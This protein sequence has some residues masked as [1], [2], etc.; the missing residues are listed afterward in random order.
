M[1]VDPIERTR[2]QTRKRKQDDLDSTLQISLRDRR[3]LKKPKRYGEACSV[4]VNE[5]TS[6]SD[7]MLCRD[8][9]QWRLAI[10]EELDSLRNND[11][12]EIIDR[13]PKAE[14]IDTK[15]VFKVKLDSSGNI[16][17]YKARLCAR[18]FKQRQGVNYEETYAPVVRYE[19]LRV[20]FAVA[21]RLDLEMTQFDVKTAFLYG[22][23]EEEI[24]IEIPVGLDI[25]ERSR[26]ACRLKKALYGLKQASRCWN[27]RFSGFLSKHGFVRC[28]SEWSVFTCK[29]GDGVMF[30]ALFVD[31]GM[32]FGSSKVK[33]Q[34]IIDE[35]KKRV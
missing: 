15:W 1:E 5:P 4:F 32:I 3:Y 27:K 20:L 6:H 11:T 10:Q 23:L 8:R 22:E 35:L 21:A 29:D 19:S 2:N 28:E 33:I 30:L 25:P 12:W 13:P 26:K 17:R 9:E 7:A 31:D 16:N 18:V 34:C 14:L 24:L